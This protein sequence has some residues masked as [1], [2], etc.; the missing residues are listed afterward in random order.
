MKLA[1]FLIALFSFYLIIASP[2][3][4][5]ADVA[6]ITLHPGENWIAA[7]L[8]P[9]NPDPVDMFSGFNIDGKLSRFDVPSQSLVSYTTANSSAFGNV[10]LGDGYKVYNSTSTS[11]V[12][13]Y[14]GVA[15]GVPGSE[16]PTDMW[17][18]LP[19]DN[20]DGQN[21]GGIHWIGQPF[22]HNTAVE[23]MY[24]LYESNL[25]SVLEAVNLGWIDQL[26]LG[27][28][29][30]TQKS[31]T[32]GLSVFGA[33]ENYF[34]A[35]HMYEIVTHKD[36]LALIIPS[37]PYVPEPSS[38]LSLLALAPLAIGFIKRRS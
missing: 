18:S 3:D 16:G 30:E 11:V 26:W 7:P 37:T 24:V 14:N 8:V 15:D 25:A 12:I 19:G 21:N 2:I 33:D 6:S 38:L 22:N 35:G 10:L 1:A 36:D 4:A 23:S 34:R 17:I 5:A 28:D 9:F 31:F 29:G 20:T 13:N 27:F 32:A